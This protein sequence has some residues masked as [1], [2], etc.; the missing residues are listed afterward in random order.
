MDLVPVIF[1][2]F[3]MAAQDAS[4]D[5]SGEGFRHFL[6]EFD[7]ARIFVRRSLLL[8]VVL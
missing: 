6:N 2:G 8:D 3:G 5:F 1:S 7:F 4:H